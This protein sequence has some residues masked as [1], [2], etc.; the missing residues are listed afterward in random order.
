ML[1][2]IILEVDYRIDWARWA[3]GVITYRMERV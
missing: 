1:K 2:Y 3:V